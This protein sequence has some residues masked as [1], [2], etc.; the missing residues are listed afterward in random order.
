MEIIFEKYIKKGN[1][2][3]INLREDIKRDLLESGLKLREITFKKRDFY[4]AYSGR[5]LVGFF[6]MHFIHKKPVLEYFFIKDKYRKKNI[7]KAFFKKIKQ[8]LI[9]NRF[10]SLIIDVKKGNRFKYLNNFVKK[11]LRK[12]PYSSTKDSNYYVIFSHEF[13]EVI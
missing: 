11:I 5:D 12:E 6:G 2:V 9:S 10:I 4:I 3:S 7:H 13:N 8:I 1:R